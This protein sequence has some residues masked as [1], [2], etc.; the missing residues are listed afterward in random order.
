MEE[1]G[2]EFEYHGEQ[3]QPVHL[4]IQARANQRVP[5]RQE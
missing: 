3:L 4:S 1:R 5:Q 2:M